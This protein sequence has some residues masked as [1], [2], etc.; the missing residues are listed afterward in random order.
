VSD[1][2]GAT[3]TKTLTITVTDP[4]GN[5]APTVTGGALPENGTAPLETELSAEGTDPDGDSL[6]YEWDF[7][8]GSAKGSGIKLKHT[9]SRVGTYTAT[10]TASDGHGGTATDT[11]SIVVGNPA[12]NQAP[13][14]QVTAD[15]KTGT[16]PLTVEFSSQARDPEG[17]GLLYVWEFG[18]DGR[19]GGA[20]ATHTYTT[21][22]VYTAKLTV[23]DP[24]GASSS[25][26]V[27]ITVTAVQG[28]GGSGGEEPAP[29]QAAWFGVAKP[30]A[31]T[32]ARFNK[33]GLAVRVTCTE[34]MSGSA[35]MTVSSALMR[36]LGLKRTTVAAGS[37]RCGGPGTKTATL[38]PSKDVKRALAAA[39]GSVKVTLDVRLQAAG[40]SAKNTTRQLTLKR[41]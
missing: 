14:V 25:A 12:G 21:P 5:L 7:G 19:A 16:S 11:V 36:K 31:T 39:R 13:S 24:G 30:A 23:T 38:K 3:G 35:T 37:V 34:A 1:A 33:R 41:R 4:P 6:T 10:V 17:A 26:S 27:Q 40:E 29:K 20:T 2:A 22:G 28:G 32:V 9:Y 18:D 8:D 15:P